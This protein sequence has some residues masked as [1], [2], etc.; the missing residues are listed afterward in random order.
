M[1]VFGVSLSIIALV[2]TILV[3]SGWGY[4]LLI[5]G[6][7]NHYEMI[8]GSHLWF[9]IAGWLSGFI[10]HIQLRSCYRCSMYHPRN[11]GADTY[12]IIG[13]IMLG[14]WLQAVLIMEH[15]DGMAWIVGSAIYVYSY[16]LVH[17]YVYEIRRKSRSKRPVGV[18][19]IALHLIPICCL[20]C[21]HCGMVITCYYG[22]HAQLT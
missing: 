5:E 19:S 13:C 16:W 4:L 3:R 1:F 18:V 21:L 11:Q 22:S 15:P 17:L 9:G 8:L 7:L 20:L 12:W 2:I 14:V 10:I 6:T